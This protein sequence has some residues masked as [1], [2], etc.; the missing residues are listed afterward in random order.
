MTAIRTEVGAFGTIPKGLVKGQKDLKI[1]GQVESIQTT[2]LL[3][4]YLGQKTRPYSNQH[5]KKKR[6][7]KIVDFAVPP[8]HRIKLEES[9]MKDEYLDLAK[10]IEKTSK[11]WNIKVAIIPIVIGA[12]VQ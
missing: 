11:L 3:T 2:V 9:E 7:R 5:K 12:S 8:D 1:R 4:H 10:G 6:I